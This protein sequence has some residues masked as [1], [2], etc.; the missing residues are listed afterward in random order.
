MRKSRKK[1]VVRVHHKV[2]EGWWSLDVIPLKIFLVAMM[3][4]DEKRNKVEF[5]RTE[6]KEI[7]SIDITNL[8]AKHRKE[9]YNELFNARIWVEKDDRLEGG[10]IVTYVKEIDGIIHLK[11]NEELEKY[12]I[13]ARQKLFVRMRMRT[14]SKLRGKYSIR[15][16]MLLQK[17]AP[18]MGLEAN[19]EEL[20]H[21]LLI[22][23]TRY[24]RA[25]DFVKYVIRPAVKEINE[26][27][28]IGIDY[29]LIR[30]GRAVRGV[31]FKIVSRKTLLQ[32]AQQ[33]HLAVSDIRTRDFNEC[34]VTLEDG[35]K[36]VVDTQKFL[37]QTAELYKAIQK[38]SR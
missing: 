20:K 26:H 27:T 24:K 31:K 21:M 9:I 32:A 8:N 28:G 25:S 19:I 30:R 5:T 10:P 22:D 2:V 35:T 16:Y 14:L 17:H 34:I 11:F 4:Y 29:E 18:L 15:L 36:K 37:A 38:Q 7:A 3:F 12:I 6:L 13:E 1:D 23:I 33:A